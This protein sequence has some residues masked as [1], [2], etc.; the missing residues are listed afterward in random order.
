M[1]TPVLVTPPDAI[2]PEALARAAELLRNGGLVAF[3]TE[4]VYGLGANALDRTAV[5]RIFAAKGRPAHNPLIVHVA[6]GQEVHRVAADWPAEAEAL[7]RQFWPGPL[8]LVLPGRDEVPDL[9]T[10]GGPTVAVRCPSHPVARALLRVVGL[11]LAAPSA[12]RSNQLSPTRA[13]HVLR[14]L[15]GRIDLI[16]DGGPTPGGIES[17]VL[18]LTTRPARLLRPGL[19]SPGDLEQV[20]GPIARS[21]SP[22]DG[23]E[24]MRSPGMLPRHYAPRTPLECVAGD[25]RARVEALRAEGLRV[26]WIT[27]VA[28]EVG[29]DRSEVVVLP[30]DPAGYAA[31][32]YDVLHELDRAGLDRI[33]V[34]EPPEGEDWLGIRDRLWRASR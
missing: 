33:M 30:S 27:H 7:A 28:E 23:S 6:E 5:A 26:A 1:A 14:D 11:P 19:L 17:T 2:P 16:L 31:R 8:T 3:P 29:G 24:A 10:A 13:E 18:D 25:A 9:V 4:T 20:V 15:D 12:N 21:S 22:G 34:S 32:L